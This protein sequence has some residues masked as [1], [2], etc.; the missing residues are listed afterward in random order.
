MWQ[1]SM[2]ADKLQVL[3]TTLQGSTVWGLLVMTMKPHTMTQSKPGMQLQELLGKG[4]G[5]AKGKSR[6]KTNSK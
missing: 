5:K 6:G 3:L 2:R 1:I 4:G